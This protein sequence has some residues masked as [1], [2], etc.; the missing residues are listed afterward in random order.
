MSYLAR[1]R[2]AE[3]RAGARQATVKH[4]PQGVLWNKEPQGRTR[5]QAVYTIG[6]FIGQRPNSKTDVYAY[7][8]SIVKTSPSGASKPTVL[9]NAT[10]RK[11]DKA[12]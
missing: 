11:F 8:Y 12:R 6:A 10:A 1:Q 7:R 5:L 9:R 2:R 3:L 4:I